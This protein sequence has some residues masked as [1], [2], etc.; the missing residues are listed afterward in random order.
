V[1]REPPPPIPGQSQVGLHLDVGSFVLT[2]RQSEIVVLFFC[3]SKAFCATTDARSHSPGCLLVS[4]AGCFVDVGARLLP[5][6]E[7]CLM[8]AALMASAKDDPAAVPGGGG[9]GGGG[10][11]PP[12]GGA[13]GDGGSGSGGVGGTCL[14]TTSP[15]SDVELAAVPDVGCTICSTFC[16]SR[17]RLSVFSA[18]DRKSVGSDT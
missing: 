18:R 10:G 12:E 14:S 5:V 2:R 4:G 9:G 1:Q 7:D 16:R 13:G 3:L 6:S 8:E 11:G 15:G 17:N